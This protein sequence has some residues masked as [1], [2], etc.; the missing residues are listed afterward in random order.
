M[1][2]TVFNYLVLIPILCFSSVILVLHEFMPSFYRCCIKPAVS[3]MREDRFNGHV[4]VDNS[5]AVNVRTN[6]S[7]VSAFNKE[8]DV[9]IKLIKLVSDGIG[10][11]MWGGGENDNRF[12][13]RVSFVR[14][15][16][17]EDTLFALV[18]SE[19][20]I[21]IAID[22]PAISLTCLSEKMVLLD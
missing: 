1:L 22:N 18:G 5:C 3:K 8:L 14:Q 2:R 19:K 16:A 17:G 10:V 13:G 9:I 21:K 6:M 4:R 11:Y 20:R 12:Y 15:Y 7:F